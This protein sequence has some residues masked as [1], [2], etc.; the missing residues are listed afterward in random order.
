M[1]DC[2]IPATLKNVSSAPYD[3]FADRMNA[4]GHMRIDQAV[5]CS[6]SCQTMKK[7][8]LRFFKIKPYGGQPCRT[9]F[10][11]TPFCACHKFWRSFPSVKARGGQA[12]KQA[13]IPN[14]SSSALAPQHGAA[15]TLPRWWSAFPKMKVGKPSSNAPF[16]APQKERRHGHETRGHAA[17]LSSPV[18]TESPWACGCALQGV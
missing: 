15:P 7:P 8:V 1:P 16:P 4:N 14:P 3:F 11:K 10:L 2:N 13:A 12:V 9:T 5:P 6:S 17:I 18:L